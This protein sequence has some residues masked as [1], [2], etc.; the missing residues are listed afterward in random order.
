MDKAVAGSY[1]YNM[2]KRKV[3]RTRSVLRKGLSS[4]LAK[5]SRDIQQRPLR[6]LLADIEQLVADCERAEESLLH[7]RSLLLYSTALRRLGRT[8]DALTYAKMAL[9]TAEKN[10]LSYEKIDAAKKC[11]FLYHQLFDFEKAESMAVQNLADA[12]RHG[13]ADLEADAL[14]MVGHVFEIKDEFDKA[15]VYF[16]EAHKRARDAGHYTREVT[17]LSDL[18]RIYG[19]LGN[20]LMSLEYLERA[21]AL[22]RSKNTQSYIPTIMFRMGDIYRSINDF[23]KA[24]Q[25]YSESL[26]KAEELE[27]FTEVIESKGRLGRLCLQKREYDKA[28]GIFME[29]DK[30]AKDLDYR[31][32]NRFN[33]IAIAETYIGKHW[34]GEAKD[35][36]WKVLGDAKSQPEA[37][38]VLI[39][40]TLEQLGIVYGNLGSKKEAMRLSDFARRWKDS[41]KPGIYTS[42]QQILF[43]AK[44]YAELGEVIADVEDVDLK[45][46]SIRGRHVKF[47]PT[48]ATVSFDGSNDSTTLTPHEKGLLRRLKKNQGEAVDV[49][50]LA[51][52]LVEGA[53]ND[54]QKDWRI[55]VKVHIHHLRKKLHDDDRSIIE[56]VRNVGWRLAE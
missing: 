42:H 31:R 53:K 32:H 49:L 37:N 43:R 47:G 50:D 46:F 33:R 30:M 15:V 19:I 51:E 8:K 40:Q 4:R 56:T 3:T 16:A 55:A 25:F 12:R 6:S 11:T 35:I 36:L 48:G 41:G 28:L 39:Q 13:F 17:V 7:S 1:I 34:F 38:H 21:L 9:K 44:I 2:V 20:F 24:E 22:A 10:D 54:P 23:D 5:L 45:E 18:G 52:V 29:I 14:A 27:I 26:A